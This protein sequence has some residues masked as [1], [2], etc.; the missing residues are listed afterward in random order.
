[1]IFTFVILSGIVMLLFVYRQIR[2]KIFFPF[3]PIIMFFAGCFYIYILQPYKYLDTLL[4]WH[5]DGEMVFFQT[6]FA[7]FLSM[8]MVIAGY[9][10]KFAQQLSQKLPK[11]D[12][13]F[14]KTKVSWLILFAFLLSLSGYWFCFQSAGGL[15]HWL[16]VPR[17]GT[18]Y[19]KISIWLVSFSV[20]LPACVT[21]IIFYSRWFPGFLSYLFAGVSFLLCYLWYFYLG[22]RS[23][24]IYLLGTG[25][26]VLAVTSKRKSI[27]ILLLAVLFFF[28][29]W[30]TEFLATHREHFYD[31][32]FHPE[33]WQPVYKTE[34]PVSRGI[35]YNCM[36]TVF[37]FSPEL[38]PYNCGYP[39]LEFVTRP[40]PRSWWPGKRYPMAES[41]SDYCKYGHLTDHVLENLSVP[42]YAGPAF[43]FVS[44]YYSMG[45][46]LFLL[47]A[48][49]ATGIVFY[50]LRSFLEKSNYSQPAS[51]YYML[52][53]SNGYGQVI[54]T[55]LVFLF[56][57]WGP[58]LGVWCICKFARKK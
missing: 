36:M 10:S 40:I 14:S 7:V 12:Y 2:A 50:A 3:D 16:A 20:F 13:S 57:I 33:L 15:Q 31:L 44:F 32:S 28:L 25:C 43:T 9:C 6:S 39:L 30:Q 49:F 35:E 52:F 47:A 27:N 5:H 8:L 24:T 26:Y 19:E 21:F 37:E 23:L 11:V 1:M 46:W 55:P 53:F 48:S 4:S 34:E 42:V 51:L 38:I 18:D 45:G 56:S 22:S 29:A 17:G 58:L 54:G 41:F